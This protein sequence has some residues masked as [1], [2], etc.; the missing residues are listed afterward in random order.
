MRTQTISKDI[1]VEPEDILDRV[2]IAEIEDYLRRRM[3]RNPVNLAQAAS[4][5]AASTSGDP[6]L[7]IVDG[8][9]DDYLRGLPI[10]QTLR[11]IAYQY[12]G[13]VITSIH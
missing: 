1:D 9:V 2:P 12:C 3:A 6:L 11:Q 5:K 13:R 7:N 10:N 8:L 4:D